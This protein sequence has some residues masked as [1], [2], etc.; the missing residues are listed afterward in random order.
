V[1]LVGH[2]YGGA[3]MTNAAR[4]NPNVT[5]LVYVAAYALEQGESVDDANH[6]GGANSDLLPYI[7]LRPY[8]NA[9]VIDPAAGA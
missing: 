8:P 5:A 1:V 4:G 9:P 3:V 2:S 6:L 7:D